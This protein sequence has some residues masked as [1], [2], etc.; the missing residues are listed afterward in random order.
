MPFN[1]GI[2]DNRAE[3]AYQGKAALGAGIASGIKS[4]TGAVAEGLAARDE[5]EALRENLIY[6]GENG[7]ADVTPELL[8]K[9]DSS[10]LSAQRGLFAQTSA[11]AT[12]QQKQAMKLE[13]INAR[14]GAAQQTDQMASDLRRSEDAEQA[15]RAALD[16]QAKLDEERAVMGWHI[17][18]G[19]RSGTLSDGDAERVR[20]APDAASGMALLK[21]ITEA[22]GPVAAP[23]YKPVEVPGAGTIVIDQNTGRPVPA[24]SVIRPP[25]AST[26]SPY[27][28]PP[29][30]A[31]GAAA[32]QPAMP[33]A[34]GA[35]AAG[36]GGGFGVDWF[37]RR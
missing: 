10:S 20:S 12:A 22:T 31:A 29:M 6:L 33:A 3:Y 21:Q 32:G 8:E 35:P 24:S 4:V 37:F 15:N 1:P 5:S 2:R 36:G 16:R 19:L 9:F 23:S 17:R 28:P 13:E 30:D 18:E 26:G 34:P 11:M 27:G 14:A 25:S 7:M